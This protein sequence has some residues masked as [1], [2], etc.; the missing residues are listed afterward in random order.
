MRPGRAEGVLLGGNLAVLAALVGTPYAPPLDGAILFLEEVGEAPYRV[1]RW[2]TQLRHAGWLAA[3]R[4]VVLGDFVRCH[5]GDHGV[6][7]ED[8]LADRLGDLDVPVV[9]GLPAGH[10]D[11]NAALPFGRR[12]VLDADEGTLTVIG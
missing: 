3:V 12:V 5:P 1:D 8:V 11:Q 9:R 7:I 6:P 2:L 10:G 4:G